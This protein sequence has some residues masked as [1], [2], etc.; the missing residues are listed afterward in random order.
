L[1]ETERTY[2]S[3]SEVSWRDPENDDYVGPLT[4]DDLNDPTFG[5]EIRVGAISSLPATIAKIN[6]INLEVYYEDAN[7]SLI[8]MSGMA[9]HKSVSY[10]YAMSGKALVRSTPVIARSFRYSSVGG[11]DL[12]GVGSIT[13]FDTMLGGAFA[14]GEANVTPYF[15]TMLGGAFAGGEANVTPYFDTMLGGAFAGGKAL[16]NY[17]L[18]YGALGGVVM[19]GSSYVP[20]IRFSHTP[21]GGPVLGSNIGIRSNFWKWL[22]D[23]NCVSK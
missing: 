9:S 12:S 2:G 8:R 13:Y 5:V 21:S 11:F 7:G 14:G 16:R 18:R 17:R 19:G 10:H 3:N 23:G 15:D 22:S 1:I 20:A 6:H 4:V